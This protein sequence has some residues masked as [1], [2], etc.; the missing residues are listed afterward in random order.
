[1][2]IAVPQLQIR[3]RFSLETLAKC[4]DNMFKVVNSIRGRQV[5]TQLAEELTR[6][7]FVLQKP[8][9]LVAIT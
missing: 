9:P 1:V 4:K 7:A 5:R 3:W 8:A 6:G 2:N